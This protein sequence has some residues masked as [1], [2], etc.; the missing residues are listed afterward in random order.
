MFSDSY[1]S[2]QALVRAQADELQ[3]RRQRG[4]TT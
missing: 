3:L 1:E 4:P 2:E